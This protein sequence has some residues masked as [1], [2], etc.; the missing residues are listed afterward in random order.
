MIATL[1]PQTICQSLIALNLAG[2]DPTKEE[3]KIYANALSSH[4]HLIQ[5]SDEERI[6]LDTMCR[7][8]LQS[9]SNLEGMSHINLL[10]EALRNNI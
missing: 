9:E 2:V 4:E 3:F 1:E 8:L 5:L 6:V 7:K 10:A